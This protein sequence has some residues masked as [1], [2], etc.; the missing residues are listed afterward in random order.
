MRSSRG[1]FAA[2]L[3]TFL[4]NLSAGAD[5]PA[6]EQLIRAAVAALKAQDAKGWK[7]TFREDTEETQLDKKGKRQPTVRKTYDV[8][9]LEGDH[10]RKLILVDGKPLDAKTQQKV[11]A[12]LEKT[13]AERR[14][15]KSGVITRQISLGGLDLLETLFDNKVTGEETVLGRKTWRVESEPKPDRKPANKAEEQALS[16]RRITWFDQGEGVEVK[17][18]VEIQRAANGFQPGSVLEFE[19]GKVGDA[20]LL[21]RQILRVDLKAMMVVRARAEF[22]FHYHDY[23]RFEVESTLTTN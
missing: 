11:D 10:Y 16:A 17:R 13:R 20:W 22:R 8:I 14:K 3:L 1:V 7:Y 23:K 4:P 12:D 15:R 2:I 6:P 21:E 5:A 9:M 18:R 19:F